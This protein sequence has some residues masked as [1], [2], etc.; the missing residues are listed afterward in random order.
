MGFARSSV[1]V[2]SPGDLG[3]WKGDIC[4]TSCQTTNSKR[5]V[6][7]TPF[8][9]NLSAFAAAGSPIQEKFPP[10]FHLSFPS[11]VEQ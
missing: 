5:I 2:R 11:S 7:L 6:P 8:L 9:Q 4:F 10:M 3:S 1:H